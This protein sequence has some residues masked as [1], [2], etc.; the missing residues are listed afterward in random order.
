MIRA[1]TVQ[2]S[3]AIAEVIVETWQSAYTGIIDAEYLETLDV[4]RFV[5]IMR[6]NILGDLEK[7]F[8]WQEEEILLGF[9]S[10]REGEA[11]SHRCEIV[12]FYVLPRYQKKG[13]GRKLFQ[14]MRHHFSER[15]YTEMSLWTLKGAKNNSFYARNG[16]T[17]AKEKMLKIGDMEY[18]G[19]CFSFSLVPVSD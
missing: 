12:G 3:R 7:V 1:A 13:V 18:A 15:G 10:G 2:D 14:H 5:R 9:V 19:V 17:I 6:R 8:V 11:D 16:G 4:D